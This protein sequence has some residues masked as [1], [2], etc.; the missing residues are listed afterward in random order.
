[1]NAVVRAIVETPVAMFR[2]QP[3]SWPLATV[4]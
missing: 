2:V 3:V 4:S 1:L